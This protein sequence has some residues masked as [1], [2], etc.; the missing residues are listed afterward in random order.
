MQ[1][2]DSN[3]QDEDSNVEDEKPNVQDE[4]SNVQDENSNVQDET[5]HESDGNDDGGAAS[6]DSDS[7]SHSSSESLQYAVRRELNP[8]TNRLYDPYNDGS[9]PTAYSYSF[10][11]MTDRVMALEPQRPISIFHR[12]VFSPISQLDSEDRP[13][14]VVTLVTCSNHP[15][16]DSA[17]VLNLPNASFHSHTGTPPKLLKKPARKVV[18]KK[19]VG[20]PRAFPIKHPPS[21]K[22]RVKHVK[23]G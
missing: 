17:V 16:T 5:F 4:N 11:H 1:D 18:I 19:P 2:E 23:K 20:K 21:P 22:V 3:V 12:D 10:S 7:S 9:S 15:S 13:E 14:P 8:G 6:S